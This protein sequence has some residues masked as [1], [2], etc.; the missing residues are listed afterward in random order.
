MHRDSSDSPF[1]NPRETPSERIGNAIRR[2]MSRVNRFTRNYSELSSPIAPLIANDGEYLM[3]ISLGSPPFPVLAI[4]DT[5]SDI[6]WTQCQPCT[7][8]YKQDA[9]IFDPKLSSTYR[10]VPCYSSTCLSLVGEGSFCSQDGHSCQY[11]VKY[12]DHSHTLGDV[13]IETLALGSGTTSGYMVFPNTLFGCGHD[14]KGTFSPK[15]SGIVG[16][17]GGPAS[18]PTQLSQTIEGKFSYCMVQYFLPN[19]KA[20]TMHFG[21]NA[22][23]SGPNVV[24]T[25]LFSSQLTQTFYMVEL[26]SVSVG[27]ISMPFVGVPLESSGNIIVDSGTTLTIVPTDFLAKFSTAV[28][29]QVT[30]GTKTSDPQGLLSLCYVMDSNLKVPPVTMHFGGGDVEL[31]TINVFVPMSKRVACLAFYGNDEISIY[32]NVAQQNFLVGFDLQKQTVSFKPTFFMYLIFNFIVLK[33]LFHVLEFYLTRA[34]GFSVDM[35]H[36]DSCSSP[37]YNPRETQSERVANVVRR[38][39]GRVARFTVAPNSPP[40]V[41]APLIASDGEY[42]MNISLGLPPFPVLAITDTGSDIIWTQCKPCIDC[43]KQDAPVYDPKFSSTYRP[44]PCSSKA[45]ALLADDGGFCQSHGD[46]CQYQATYGDG[47][48]TKGDIATETL[49]LGTAAELSYVA[50]PNMIFGCGHDNTGIFSPKGA[51]IIGLGEGPASLISQLGP[52]VGG[53]FSYCMV[54][55]DA[56]PETTSTMHFGQKA[57]VSG[58]EVVTTPLLSSELG[59]TFYSLLLESVSVGSTTIPFGNSNSET[60]STGNIIIDSGTTLT[61]VPTDFLSNFA[62]AIEAQVTG[63]NKTRDPQGL[64][65][66]C[67]LIDDKLKIPPVAAYFKGGGVELT[68]VNLFVPMSKTVTCLAFYGS[69]EVSIYGNL[70]QQDFLVG[71]DL[72]KRTVSFKPTDC[73]KN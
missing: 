26:H 20:S 12:G 34:G 41:V 53:K 51:G 16:L 44:V 4:A 2:T 56:T 37:F 32:G 7:D 23:V 39:V 21:P 63:G 46:I 64:L 19:K 57:V 35:I 55:Y 62:T 36:R 38:S 70:A 17:G 66:L 33:L 48:H 28:E 65:S 61:I 43:Y 22:V 10:P 13:A 18:L 72:Q 27:S 5:G 45:C 69:D 71:Y 54:P 52:S 47:S 11:Q 25:P 67:Y 49:A 31:K 1:Y 3:N 14:N 50:F 59:S 68:P 8:C 73:T 24:S 58:G 9:P 40:D 29:S 30:G 42:L 15:G 6:I 60:S